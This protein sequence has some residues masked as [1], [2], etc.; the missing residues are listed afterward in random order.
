MSGAEIACQS[1]YGFNASSRLFGLDPSSE[2]TTPSLAR[3]RG[4]GA[5][6]GHRGQ[7]PLRVE[8]TKSRGDNEARANHRLHR[9]NLGNP[10]IRRQSSM[11]VCQVIAG[12]SDLQLLSA[13]QIAHLL[14]YVD[15]M[16]T[17]RSVLHVILLHASWP[18]DVL[19]RLG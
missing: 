15:A 5:G 6:Q 3:T 18:A 7:R 1:D 8:C 9:P 4:N 19:Q 17:I 11:G 16:R 2:T 12:N 13:P 14:R 10:L